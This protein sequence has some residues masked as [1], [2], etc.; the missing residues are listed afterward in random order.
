MRNSLRG[1]WCIAAIILM[2]VA[3]LGCGGGGDGDSFLPTHITASWTGG[4]TGAPSD[5]TDV[6][7]VDWVGNICPASSVILTNHTAAFAGINIVNNCTM[8]ATYALC[9]AKGSQVQ[10]V[11]GLSE[12]ATDPLNTSW[13][14][15]TFKTINPGAPGDFINATEI[16]SVN[17]FYCSDSQTLTGPPL[18][19]I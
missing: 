18:R 16:L 5:R 7:A 10:P 12:C 11:G 13:N 8:P 4:A 1:M 9:V 14:V 2:A 15:L 3:G 19:C 6:E 17:I